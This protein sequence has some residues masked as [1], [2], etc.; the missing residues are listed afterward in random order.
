MLSKNR[1]RCHYTKI[2]YGVKG[3]SPNCVFVGLLPVESQS[4]GMDVE[5]ERRQISGDISDCEVMY[6]IQLLHACL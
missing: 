6:I 1:K 5:T 2:A 3:Y 4:R